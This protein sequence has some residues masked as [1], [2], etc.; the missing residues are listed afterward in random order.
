MTMVN[1]VLNETDARLDMH[2]ISLSVEGMG[3]RTKIKCCETD[4]A[5]QEGIMLIGQL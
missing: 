3:G 5:T 1:R 2:N 4:E